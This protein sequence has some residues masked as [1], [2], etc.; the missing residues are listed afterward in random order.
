M[1][2]INIGYIIAGVVFLWNPS[3]SM[4]DVL[5]DVIGYLLILKGLY[6]LSDLERNLL[7][8]R[9]KF[10]NAAWLSLGK[11]FAMALIPIFDA[12]WYLILAFSFGVL[13][14]V[15]LIPAFVE[16][17]EGISYL[18]MRYTGHRTRR[19]TTPRFGGIFDKTEFAD[20]TAYFELYPGH[21]RDN[22][23]SAVAL[24]IP[25]ANGTERL[26]MAEAGFSS[27]NGE[28]QEYLYESGEAR[29]MSV[30]FVIARAVCACLP[31][32]TALMG[33]RD[34]YV[35]ANPI[36]NYSGL[37]QV[38]AVIFAAVSLVF[39][40]L[41]LVRMIRYFTRF[42][43][44]TAFITVLEQKYETEILTDRGLWIKRKTAAFGIL[45]AT[46]YLFLLCLK[47][48][49]DFG[50]VSLRSFF[51][52]PEFMWGVIMLLAFRAAGD[53]VPNRRG[54]MM[55]TGLFMVF[56]LIA[57]GIWTKYS[58]SLAWLLYPYREAGFVPV[59]TAFMIFF[60]AAMGM[61]VL[62]ILEKRRVYLRMAE[63]C[64][65]LSCEVF[66]ETHNRNRE[67]ALH[68]LA[69]KIRRLSVTEICYAVFSVLCMAVLPMADISE[70]LGLSW[71]FRM[72]FGA[73]L[74]Y[75]N[76]VTSDALKNELE[77]IIG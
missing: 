33:K 44:D 36:E 55:K 14:L 67:D 54:A 77:K 30:I 51:F 40:I 61:F 46:A 47:I 68:E 58:M 39:G 8:A 74:I 12:M 73:V 23:G 50:L 53:Y 28:K 31:E 64:T 9:K 18:E 4:V 3:V 10:K 15:W 66:G 48:D 25:F 2:A 34:G 71:A 20:G 42:R 13:E 35:E 70:L 75:R 11:L 45:S 43:R 52:V 76:A 38:L 1:I 59:F 69:R 19:Q 16:L 26:C 17:F 27:R 65:A 32:F 21:G 7:S 49:I 22:T 41:W 57:Q 60:A 5:P 72:A 56:S 63:E 6:K 24:D 62:V 29:V 37:R